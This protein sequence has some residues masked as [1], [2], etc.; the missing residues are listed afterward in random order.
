MKRAIVHREVTVLLHLELDEIPD[1]TK[2]YGTT[3]FV[4]DTI[5]ITFYSTG[6]APEWRAVR[7]VATGPRRLKSGGISTGGSL[8]DFEFKAS[9][10]TDRRAPEWALAAIRSNVPS[11]VADGDLPVEVTR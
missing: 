5:E 3:T 1:M 11:P 7:L 9:E 4:P 2:R 8:F 6:S 10:L